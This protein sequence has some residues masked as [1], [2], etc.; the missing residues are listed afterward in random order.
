MLI[1]SINLLILVI[2]VLIKLLMHVYP[3]PNLKFVCILR[4]LLESLQSS[5]WLS[6]SPG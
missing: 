5:P 2:V 1:H 6:G 3:T 4:S